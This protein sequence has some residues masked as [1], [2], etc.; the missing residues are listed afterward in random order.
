MSQCQVAGCLGT[1]NAV[2]GACS[3]CS[4]PVECPTPACRVTPVLLPPGTSWCP[5]CNK[6]S[7]DGKIKKEKSP[8]GL[9]A[10]ASKTAAK[11]KMAA[12]ATKAKAS[13]KA[14][15]AKASAKAAKAKTAASSAKGASKNRTV[16][17]KKSIKV[18]SKDPRKSSEQV[19]AKILQRNAK[20]T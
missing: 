20:K 3:Q 6:P 1:A 12:K 11:A 10:K 5:H 9:A 7:S 4:A 2:T 18:S 16:S 15:K 19:C 17:S 8:A 14:A 13:A